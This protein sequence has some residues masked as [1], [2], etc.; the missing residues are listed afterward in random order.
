MLQDELNH[1]SLL[2]ANFR[3]RGKGR[4]YP[5]ASVVHHLRSS[6]TEHPPLLRR[7]YR[8][9]ERIYLNSVDALLYNSETTRHT[10]EPLLYR[11]RPAL[12]AYPA[13]D[14][15][16]A[17]EPAVDLNTIA[18]RSRA[19]GPL[20]ILFVGNLIRRKGLDQ[21]AGCIGTTASRVLGN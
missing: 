10:V 4:R 14:H 1:P 8:E 15:L 17:D 7:L 5:V 3:R 6:E 21:A 18:E 16:P 9:I 12:V 2:W 13:A 11:S 20:R 19:P